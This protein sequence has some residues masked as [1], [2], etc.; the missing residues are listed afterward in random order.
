MGAVGEEK[1]GGGYEYICM[2]RRGGLGGR[3]DLSPTLRGMP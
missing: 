3:F 2:S 1:S